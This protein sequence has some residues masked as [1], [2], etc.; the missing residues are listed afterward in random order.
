[1]SV[2]ANYSTVWLMLKTSGE[3]KIVLV[4]VIWLTVLKDQ[5]IVVLVQLPELVILY[6]KPL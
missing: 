6:T 2:N 1:M 5:L 3:I 4:K